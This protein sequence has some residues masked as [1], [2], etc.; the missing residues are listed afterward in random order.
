MSVATACARGSSLTEVTSPSDVPGLFAWFDASQIS[1]TI[2]AAL[3][4]W[5]ELVGSNDATQP[6]SGKRPLLVLEGGD[7]AVLFDGV[8]DTLDTASF[9]ALPQPFTVFTVFRAS[10][11]VIA[12]EVAVGGVGTTGYS[13]FLADALDN[14]YEGTMIGPQYTDFLY[15]GLK[16]NVYRIQT[17]SIRPGVKSSSYTNNDRANAGLQMGNSDIVSFTLGSS[18]AIGNEKFMAGAIREVIIYNRA[19]TSTEC[20]RVGRYL[21][22]KWDVYIPRQIPVTRGPTT[23]AGRVGLSTFMRSD[24]LDFTSRSAQAAD[25]ASINVD[26]VREG[27]DWPFFETSSG[28]WDYSR[29]DQIMEACARNGLNMLAIL[30]YSPEWENGGPD[31]FRPPA[32]NTDFANYCTKVVQRYGTDGTFWS[33]NPTVPYLPVLNWEMWNEPWLYHFWLPTPDPTAFGVLAKAGADA[34]HA[35]DPA[36]T[37]LLPMDWKMI[38]DA[39]TVGDWMLGVYNADTTVVDHFDGYAMHAYPGISADGPYFETTPT[40]CF[41]RSRITY[42]TMAAL[43]KQKPVWITEVGWSTANADVGGVSEDVQAERWT[44]CIRRTAID[45]RAWCPRVFLYA[46]DYGS[47]DP[48]NWNDNLPVLRADG[49][50]KPAWAALAS[51]LA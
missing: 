44:E 9:T 3:T 40:S 38:I 16:E 47:T 29:Y 30:T 35:A 50:K 39:T 48:T 34:V 45:Y 31:K 7:Q 51:Y 6:T 20:L 22:H 28:V 25:I 2:N 43:G 11:G 41:G 15:G 8:D 4:T 5:P 46:Y 23:Y 12:D 32:S 1:G 27:F 14:G 49:S 37:V 33:A 36:A 42:D 26:W 10:K 24:L 19:L 13:A 21:A 17:A 18:I